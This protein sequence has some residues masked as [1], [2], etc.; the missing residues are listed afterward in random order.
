ML[1][2]SGSCLPNLQNFAQTAKQNGLDLPIYTDANHYEAEVRGGQHRRCDGQ[3]LHALRLRPVRGGRRQGDADYLDVVEAAGGEISLLG[4]A[5]D[6]VVPALGHGR[7]ECGAPLTRDVR[8]RRTC[9]R[10]NEWTAG[11]L[12]AETDPGGNHPPFCNVVLE[13]QRHGLRAGRPP[14]APR[15]L[16]PDMYICKVVGD[17]GTRPHRTSTPNRIPTSSADRSGTSGRSTVGRRLPARPPSDS[18]HAMRTFS[19]TPFSASASVRSI[20]IA[21]TG[22]IVT[23]T[24]SGIFNFAH[25]AI[26]MLSAVFYWQLHSDNGGWGIPTGPVAC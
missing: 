19:L 11:G 21:A 24:T 4:D 13:A 1:V 15:R 7:S 26:G 23:Y 16:R 25:G 17:P 14:T 5:G 18:H 2:W 9:R 12:H 3:R 22:L 8:A 20:A 6:L 10:S